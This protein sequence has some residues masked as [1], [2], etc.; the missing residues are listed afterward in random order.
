MIICYR[1]TSRQFPE[2]LYV[3]MDADAPTLGNAGEE[4][5]VR[6]EIPGR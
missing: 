3:P 1:A 5:V 4:Y 6:F 2:N